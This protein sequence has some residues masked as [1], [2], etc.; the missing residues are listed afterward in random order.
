MPHQ[1]HILLGCADARD[2]S[3]FH[4]E[5]IRETIKNYKE[6]KNIH[7]T[8]QV[9]RSPGSF[10]TEDVVMDIKRIIEYNQRSGSPKI[11]TDYYIHLQTHGELENHEY[12]FDEH[13]YD[14]QVVS[15]S[16]L[17]CGMLGATGVG[18]ELEKLILSEKPALSIKGKKITIDS[19]EKIRLLLTEK[20][21]F[22]GY[23]AGDWIKS[24]DDLRTHPRTQRAILERVIQKDLDLRSLHIYITAGI[25]DYSLHS[26]IRLDG[27]TPRSS[28]WEDV[29]QRILHKL[30]NEPSAKKILEKQGQKQKPLA[31]LLFVTD[32]RLHPHHLAAQ[33]Y[34]NY[35]G[36]KSMDDYLPNTLFNLSGSSFDMPLSPFG[37]Y[38]I[39]GFFYGVKFLNLTDQLVMGYDKM[40][41]DR[42]LKKIQNDPL[43]GLIVHKF[44]V[45]LI[46]V[47]QKELEKKYEKE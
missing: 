10:V 29:H 45:N 28:F 15:G 5:A 9:I 43:M 8:F 39:A 34:L 37:P 40:Q 35:K 47:N 3:Q 6:E 26:L 36:L 31:G 12:H 13:A 30:K 7:I 19:E 22:E 24:I 46:P 38:I 1:V 44:G 23:L 42:I 11:A 14:V 2:L 16:Q 17:N 32:P 41:T 25:Q 4:V 21:A 20:Y 33:F 27:G 18:I